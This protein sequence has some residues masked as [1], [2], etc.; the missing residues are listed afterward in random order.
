MPKA[1]IKYKGQ[2]SNPIVTRIL[3]NNANI[4]S[5]VLAKTRLEAQRSLERLPRGGTA[6]T[7]DHFLVRVFP[8]VLFAFKFDV[9]FTYAL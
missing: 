4:E 7:L 9:V 8:Y 5:R 2:I 3:V 6:F 1:D